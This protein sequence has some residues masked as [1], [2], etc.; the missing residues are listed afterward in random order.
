MMKKLKALSAQDMLGV[1]FLCGV[2]FSSAMNLLVCG[3]RT[4][5]HDRSVL[6]SQRE[7]VRET[8]NIVGTVG[9]VLDGATF[10]MYSVLEPTK[11]VTVHVYGV[12]VQSAGECYATEAREA[13]AQM[14]HTQNIEVRPVDRS[15]PGE[16]NEW[17]VMLTDAH[18]RVDNRYLSAELILAGAARIGE[19]NS[20]RLAELHE[21]MQDEA[22]RL[23]SGLWGVCK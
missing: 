11:P 2:L 12:E 5:M 17:Y 19:V 1:G 16:N 23:G 18:P 22:K 6:A 8:G 10:T 9:E 14:L 4:Y 13:L 3:V 7:Y 21:M 20:E 15:T